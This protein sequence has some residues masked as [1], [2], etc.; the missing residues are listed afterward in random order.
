[1]THITR[2]QTS[3]AALS[4]TLCAGLLMAGALQAQ[5]ITVQIGTRLDLA[6]TDTLTWGQLGADISFISAFPAN[7]TTTGGA[8]GTVNNTAGDLTRADEGGV[9][10]A[11]DF[12]V[13]AQLLG[14]F[15]NAGPLVISFANPVARVGTQIQSNEWVAFTGW[16]SAFDSSNTLLGT[17]SIGGTSGF[18]QAN[19]APFLGIG[20][21]SLNISSVQFSVTT[22]T[23]NNDLWINTVDLS[24]TQFVVAPIP[25][26]QAYVLALAGVA[27]LGLAARRRRPVATTLV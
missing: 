19:T 22:S 3:L 14:T 18:G 24:S 10:F 13:G 25:E 8:T 9:A 2:A 23:P 5:A 16:M 12:A 26:P 21:S 1:M 20:S 7:F 4:R 17:V 27:M 6:G 11:G 15:G